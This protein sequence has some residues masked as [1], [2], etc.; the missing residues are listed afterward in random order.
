MQAAANPITPLVLTHLPV[1]ELLKAESDYLSAE[2]IAAR[3]ARVPSNVRRDMPRLVEAGLVADEDRDGKRV[4]RLDLVGGAGA[5]AAMARA[6][7]PNAGAALP[8]ALVAD[9]QP[10]PFN[11]RKL[12]TPEALATTADTI[13]E[14]GIK[15]PLLVRPPNA[16]GVRYIV[17]GERRWRAAQ[18]VNDR[19]GD[20]ARVRLPYIEEAASEEDLEIETAYTALVVNGQHENLTSFERA[21]ALRKLI[22]A[23]YPSARAAAK[24]TGIHE[25]TAQDWMKALAEL[26]PA[27]LDQ[28]KSGALNWRDVRDRHLRPQEPTLPE[29]GQSDIEDYAPRTAAVDNVKLSPGAELAMIEIAWAI[30]FQPFTHHG[31]DPSAMTNGY[32]YMSESWRELTTAGLIFEAM[33]PV[34]GRRLCLTA[35]TAKGRAWIDTRFAT[36]PIDDA[37]LQEARDRIGRRDK[38][39]GAGEDLGFLT[40]P[41]N[42]AMGRASFEAGRRLYEQ[43]TPVEILRLIEIMSKCSGKPDIVKKGAGGEIL[44]RA[45]VRRAGDQDQTTSSLIYADLLRNS[46]ERGKDLIRTTPAGLKLLIDH[47]YNGC[48]DGEVERAREAAG[49]SDSDRNRL[50]ETGCYSTP[51]LNPSA[52]GAVEGLVK[53]STDRQEPDDELQISARRALIE[54]THKMLT[55]NVATVGRAARVGSYWLDSAASDLVDAGLLRFVQAGGETGWCVMWGDKAYA[56]LRANAGWVF[57]E[58]DELVISADNLAQVQGGAGHAWTGPGYVTAWLNAAPPTENAEPAPQESLAIAADRAADQADIDMAADEDAFSVVIEMLRE[59]MGLSHGMPGRWNDEAV[60]VQDLALIAVKEVQRGDVVQAIAAM[61]GLIERSGGAF[62]ADGLLRRAS[63]GENRP[64][65]QDPASRLFRAAD[66]ARTFMAGV[67]YDHL[68]AVPEADMV[69]RD[70]SGALND[71]TQAKRQEPAADAL[72]VL[73]PGAIV[74]KHPGAATQHRLLERREVADKR[75]VFSAQAIRNGKDYGKP[76]ALALNEIAAVIR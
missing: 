38:V 47:G 43:P 67:G 11:P 45:L 25:K 65:G 12:F 71:V 10:N 23:R 64:E 34:F 37:A 30:R 50:R 24:A 76:S 35:P 70:L 57:D 72:L 29:P 14:A 66:A 44:D 2:V 60:T 39:P 41:L 27:I 46:H 15:T 59:T 1:L 42:A 6:A 69:Y 31:G 61:V 17:D 28:W 3:T 75:V 4:Y 51:W 26:S 33:P 63:E 48:N 62:E 32:T 55:A 36:A 18:I 53:T 40:Y 56:W 74:E 21:T 54:A 68:H 9:L 49:I 8:F 73:K 13:D 5:L 19:H 16:E 58:A 22:P 52:D 20:P 7:D